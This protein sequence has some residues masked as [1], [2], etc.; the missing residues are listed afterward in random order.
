MLVS[1]SR[2]N[3]DSKKFSQI[4]LKKL[5]AFYIDRASLISTPKKANHQMLFVY[6]CRF[7]LMQ[8]MCLH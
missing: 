2:K 8:Q 7:R 3:D 5:F 6:L 1:L 4:L